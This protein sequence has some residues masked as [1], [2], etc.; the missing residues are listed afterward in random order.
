MKTTLQYRSKA[1]SLHFHEYIF[2][3]SMKSLDIFPRRFFFLLSSLHQVDGATTDKKPLLPTENCN[4]IL[5]DWKMV[6][7]NFPNALI[8]KKSI[9]LITFYHFSMAFFFFFYIYNILIFNMYFLHICACLRC[10]IFLMMI[11]FNFVV[12]TRTK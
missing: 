10:P 7:F 4:T 9:T 11:K 5:Y 1:L 8:L 2:I 12:N 6:R 3:F